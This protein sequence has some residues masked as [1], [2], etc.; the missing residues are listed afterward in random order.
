M[1]EEGLTDQELEAKI[2][3]VE[4]G[5]RGLPEGSCLY[6]Y[7]RVISGFDIPRQAKYADPITQSFVD[8]RLAFLD[9]TA[10]FRRIDLHWCLTFEPKLINPFAA[11]PKDQANENARLLA[12]LQKAASILETHLNVHI[13]LSLLEKE[14]AFQFFCELFNLGRVGRRDQAHRRHRR[15]SADREQRRIVGTRPS[16][17]R[18]AL[19]PDVHDDGH[20]PDIPA[21][22]V[23]RA[24]RT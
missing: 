20:A 15:R 6:Q 1:D 7:M 4:G 21:V 11:K 13:G 2:R 16:A 19:R 10:N 14:Q 17:S 23:F 5:L 8:D 12:D 9:K 22:P 3:A 18:Q 24:S